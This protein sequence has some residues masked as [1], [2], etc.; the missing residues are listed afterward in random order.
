MDEPATIF[1]EYDG[2]ELYEDYY[3]GGAAETE[4][5]TV[6]LYH[7][8]W[9]EAWRFAG[10]SALPLTAMVFAPSTGWAVAIGIFSALV[11]VGWQLGSHYRDGAAANSPRQEQGT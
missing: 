4:T 11:G 5:S 1:D 8:E 6:V 3:Q 9:R 10:L 7:G 2:S